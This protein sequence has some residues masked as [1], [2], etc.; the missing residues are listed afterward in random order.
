MAGARFPAGG[1]QV[2]AVDPAAA[3]RL[4]IPHRRGERSFQ[5]GRAE[6][7]LS[8]DARDARRGVRGP[9]AADLRG[10]ARP[11]APGD[12]RHERPLRAAE[13]RRHFR[14]PRL[15]HRAR[16]H[17]LREARERVHARRIPGGRPR[18][19]ERDRRRPLRRRHGGVRTMARVSSARGAA[20]ALGVAAALAPA[21]AAGQA[22]PANPAGRQ[23]VV[24]GAHYRAGWFHRLLL[25][26]H[27][28]DLWTTPLEVEVLDLSR[29][30]GGLTP[31]RCG[32]RRQTKVL[33]FSSADG[34]D[35]AFRSVDKDPT[36]ALP[37]ELRATF[38]REMIQDQISSAHP[39]AP[40]V[41]APLL[42]AASVLNAEPRLFVLPDDRRLTGI[43]CA[44]P[45]ELGMI[46][47]RPTEGP[48]GEPTVAGA[49]DL[50]NTKKLFEHLERSSRHRV[51]SR[52]FLAARL[53]DVFIG[54]WDRHQ[55]QWRWARFD[56]VGVH[57]WRPIP[58][59]GAQAFARL[60]GLLVWLTGFYQPQVVGF[61]D[62]YPSIWR[63]TFAGQVPDRRLLVDIEKPVWDSVAK[64][65]QAQLTDSVIEVA[66]RRLPP[67][68]YAKSG[69]ALTHA[70][71]RRRDRLPYITDRYYSLLAG[72]VEIH[73][74]D[75]ADL[76]E[77]ERLAGG[78]VTVRLSPRSG[79]EPY[80]RRRFDRRATEEVRLFLH[81]GDDQL[82]VRGSD[83]SGPLVRVIAGGGDDELVGSARAGSTH[84]YDDRRNNRFVT[85]PGTS[86]DRRHYDDPPRDT[87]TLGLPRDWGSLWVPLTWVGYTPDVGL[88]VGAGAAGTGYGFRR[89]P[90]NSHVRVRAG[91]A[92]SAATYRA[93]LAG[94]FRGIVPPAIVT[95]HLRASGIDVL[96]F[97]DFGN[98]TRDTGSTDFH[99]VKQQQYLLAPALQF[100]LS[101]AASLT[102]GPELKFAHTRLEDSTL[103]T[104]RRPYG[105]GDF[106]QVGA[107][108][109]LR[110]DTRDRPQAASR[111][112]LFSVGGG[113]Y[114]AALGVTSTVGEGHGEAATDLS[115]AV[116]LRPTLA[117]PV[118]GEQG[119]G[120]HPPPAAA[121]VGGSSTVRGFPEHRFAGDAATYGNA[122]LRLSIAKFF[123]LLPNELGVFGLADAGRVFV[124]GQ[125]SD[126]WHAAAGGG[127]WIAFLSRANILSVAAA[128]SVEG[129]RVYVRTEI[130]RAHV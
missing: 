10:G 95:L 6:R 32:G 127:L 101:S 55:D 8:S 120:A 65:I 114:P 1:R 107:T 82:V 66:V 59:D 7:G 21:G 70:L 64:A 113:V 96:R 38:V 51:D 24:A 53:M 17:A 14:P 9:P 74:T 16:R 67:E 60:D 4:G 33:R 123:L 110:L 42:D 124:S 68:Y 71:R 44:F 117:L 11:R 91:Y 111:G 98:Q 49:V 37:P 56:S 22:G 88:F 28:R 54:D 23:T 18:P 130:G 29:F 25:G 86:V 46:E 34:R 112:V 97:Y 115:A 92:T 121:Y 26:A 72:V 128:H 45:G 43:V 15:R 57:R 47:E 93:E 108:A 79:G 104:V 39:G 103:V 30:A 48:D 83:G 119:W 84:F 102:L 109:G 99:K 77:V 58:R 76:A 27:Y 105:V 89:L 19:P 118:A 75:E 87:S 63:L 122:E 2:V 94:E 78:R 13:R 69:A 126:R 116:P 81:G 129:T 62:D 85:G 31:S 36:L 125:T 61:G 12:R 106:G 80:Y 52:A 73:A 20:L 35:Y 5:S 50:A 3:D 41:V 90:Y 100:G 40:L